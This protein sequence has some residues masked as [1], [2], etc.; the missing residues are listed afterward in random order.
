MDVWYFDDGDSLLYPSASVDMKSLGDLNEQAEEGL[1]TL[2]LYIKNASRYSV[3][4]FTPT[5]KCY[6]LMDGVILNADWNT[7]KD[8]VWNTDPNTRIES[9][10]VIKV[11]K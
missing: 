1:T 6:Y 8:G 11:K 10:D 4:I 7:Y 2:S 9:E 5:S 3:T